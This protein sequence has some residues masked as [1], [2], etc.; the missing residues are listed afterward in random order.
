MKIKDVSIPLREISNIHRE[1]VNSLNFSLNGQY[2]IT[3]GDDKN[4]KIFDSSVDKIS[5]YYFQSFI[6]HTFPVTKAFFNPSNNKQ[7][8]SIGGRDGIHLWK[9]NGDTKNLYEALSEELKELKSNTKLKLSYR[10]VPKSPEKPKITS[11]LPKE[12][13]KSPCSDK[14]NVSSNRQTNSPAPS[15]K[16]YDAYKDTHIDQEGQEFNPPAEEL[17]QEDSPQ[18][19]KLE[20]EVHRYGYNG[21]TAQDNLVWLRQRNL[22]VFSS[23]NEIVVEDRTTGEQTV[24]QDGHEGEVAALAVDYEGKLLASCAS[25]VDQQGTAAIILWDLENGFEKKF[26]MRSHE[27]GVKNIIFSKDGKYLISQGCN[28]ERSLVLWDVE[29]GLVIKSTICPTIYN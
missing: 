17:P 9:F 14:E 19:E 5:P 28:E 4:V 2:L 15:H 1:S 18:E 7:C 6:G 8:I 22:I 24:L 13:P 25:V 20:E 10:G 29:E 26:E 27:I 12:A 16:E 11:S 3:C 23:G 21:V